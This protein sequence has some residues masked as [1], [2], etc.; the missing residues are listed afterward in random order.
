MKV[1]QSHKVTDHSGST[2]D[3][4]LER[5]GIREEV[6]A[7]A[8]ERVLIWKFEQATQEQQKTRRA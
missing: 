2:F 5:E 7:V 3:S 8:I 6:E 1:R 4:Y